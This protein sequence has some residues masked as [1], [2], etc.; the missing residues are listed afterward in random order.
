MPQIVRR[1]GGGTI[2]RRAR[3]AAGWALV[4]QAAGQ[5][6][7]S[8]LSGS[9]KVA[10]DNGGNAVVTTQQDTATLYRRR[11][12]PK[13]LR[14]KAKRYQRFVGKVLRANDTRL[15]TQRVLLVNNFLGTAS[16]LGTQQVHS[17]G[18]NMYGNQVLNP[19]YRDLYQMYTAY[20]AN[21]GS[22]RKMYFKSAHMEVAVTNTTAFS[23][24]VEM[25]EFVCRKD[26]NLTSDINVDLS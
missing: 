21:S 25:Y 1:T 7:R 4:A 11:R 8:A 14:R 26:T 12:A 5:A 18:L 23:T 19:G 10:Q 3:R 15:A 9:K 6:V 2:A 16:T 20:G 22:T 24:Y 17:V 13:W